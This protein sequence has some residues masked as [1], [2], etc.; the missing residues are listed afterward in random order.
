MALTLIAA[1]IIAFLMFWA[2]GNTAHA[3]TGDHPHLDILCDNPAF[4]ADT[5][6]PVGMRAHNDYCDGPD[7]VSPRDYGS[8]H[9]RPEPPVV[10]PP[11]PVLP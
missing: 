4:A 11:P 9:D 1:I 7:V 6:N 10:P 3:E 8:G 2:F 5:P